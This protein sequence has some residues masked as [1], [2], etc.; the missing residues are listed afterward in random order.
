M[1]HIKLSLRAKKCR[2]N[3]IQTRF[4]LFF[5]ILILI[6]KLDKKVILMNNI[7]PF[8]KIPNSQFFLQSSIWDLDKLN[9]N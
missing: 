8:K 9:L 4:C 3:I 7:F 2:F 1:N 6:L 5:L